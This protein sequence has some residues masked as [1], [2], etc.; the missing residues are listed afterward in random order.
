[1][2][3]VFISYDRATSRD[4]AAALKAALGDGAFLD[5]SEIAD[6][7]AF[8]ETLITALLGC[9]VVVVLA[10]RRYF[11]RDYCLREL[12][13]AQA[14]A[15]LVVGLVD[16]VG[17]LDDLAPEWRD[18]NWPGAG[19][20]GRLVALVEAALGRG[21]ALRWPADVRERFLAPLV[22]PM[23]V[24]T[25]R[26]GL[27][28]ESLGDRF[29]GR[30]RDLWRIHRALAPH[31]GQ[32]AVAALTGVVE[33]GGGFGK[34]R[35]AA[36]YVWRYGRHYPGGL[37]WLDAEDEGR[38]AAQFHEILCRLRPET[39]D[40]KG[41]TEAG[42][43]ARRELGVVFEGLERPA[44]L[45]VDNV[46]EA[47][48]GAAP[49]G[50][51]TY[52]PGRGGPVTVLATSRQRL[53]GFG[54][55]VGLEIETLEEEAAV[56]LLSR[57]VAG[58]LNREEWGEVAGWVGCLPLAL[59]LLNAAMR[60]GEAAGRVLERARGAEAGAALDGMME[61]LRPQV[62]AG[63]LRGVTEALWV[64]YE[65]L[66]EEWREA[67]RLMAQLGPE[68]IPMEVAEGLGG[69]GARAALV[70]HSV[71]ERVAG[72]GV[73]VYGRMHRIMGSFL[74]GLSVG[75]G[76]RE[77]VTG[78][79]CEV[80]DPE[81][82]RRPAE[83]GVLNLV[84]PHA[85]VVF[86]RAVRGGVGGEGAVRLGQRVGILQRAQGQYWRAR[87]IEGETVELAGRVLGPEHPD[88]LTSMGNLASSLK[89][90]GDLAGARE[91]QEQVVASLKRVLGT[92]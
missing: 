21:V 69:E 79:L 37:F 64:T 76:E 30:E 62:P 36:E 84:S 81:R 5:T 3:D 14:G 6:G 33:G 13:A 1:M 70:G 65:R 74:R 35:L 39:P 85:E 67:A 41:F 38:L 15:E 78:V 66:A 91:L 44:L 28:P 83:W 43:D 29:V 25:P 10:S 71:V 24:G 92:C 61:T 63:A 90:G 12:E 58:Q 19:E 82:C 46:P 11:T 22:R 57:G 4:A 68:V 42:R 87:T 80:M 60:M 8:P 17:D 50:V 26:A 55:V 59:E 86:G 23:A 77:R 31:E 20:T 16:G 73:P 54:G 27:I 32:A 7:A 51:G 2:A 48:A 18:R 75:D 9:R 34:T 49:V 72:G 53:G 47:S 56:R 45:V 40:W 89:A 88:T 52:R